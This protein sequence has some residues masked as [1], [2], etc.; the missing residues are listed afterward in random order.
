M[1]STF[2]QPPAYFEPGDNPQQ[3]WE[4]WKEAYNIY[5]QACEYSTKPTATRRALLLHVLGPDG[6]RVG[7]TFF[8][9]LP[10]TDGQEPTDQVAYLLEQFDALCR[11]YKNGGNTG[12]VGGSVPVFDELVLSTARMAK[13][14]TVD[15]LSGEN[16]ERQASGLAGHK[17]KG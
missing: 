13:V 17:N 14:N 5:E 16:Q 1:A 10:N 6:R 15:P 7:Q 3:A 9:T 12:L 2:L 11:P 4:D 8:P